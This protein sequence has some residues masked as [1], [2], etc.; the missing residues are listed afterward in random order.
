VA[1][2]GQPERADQLRRPRAGL[3]AAVNRESG[4][5]VRDVDRDHPEG[6]R[7]APSGGTDRLGAQ[8]RHIRGRAVVNRSPSVAMNKSPMMAG[9]ESPLVARQVTAQGGVPPWDS[10]GKDEEV[11]T[12]PALAQLLADRAARSALQ[13]QQRP[14]ADSDVSA[15]VAGPPGTVGSV[16]P[17]VAPDAINV[18]RRTLYVRVLSAI[19]RGSEVQFCVWVRS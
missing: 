18:L 15:L 17:G 9:S 2:S 4:R 19:S 13:F 1:G 6:P 8:L 10:P 11:S 14:R 7:H 16:L 3:K 5:G 12:S